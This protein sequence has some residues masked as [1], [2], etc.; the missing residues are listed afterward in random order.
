MANFDQSIVLGLKRRWKRAG[1]T[2]LSVLGSVWLVTEVL[3]R[4][5]YDTNQWLN[6]HGTLYLILAVATA[7]IGFTAAAYEARSVAFT[8]PNTDT[9]LTLRFGSIFDEDADWIIGVNELFDSTLGNIVSANSLH[10]QIIA[11]VY[12]GNE[13][14][15]RRDIDAAL[16]NFQGQAVQRAEGQTVKYHLGTTAVI[17]RGARK[18]F[19]VAISKT[20]LVTHRSSSTVPILWDALTDAIKEVDRR[21]NGDP[22]ALPLIGNGRAS[23]NIPPQ[24]LLRIITLKLTEL[25]KQYD[26]PRRITIN[27]SDDCFEHLDLVEIKRGWSVV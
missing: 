18:I 19:L 15:F 14:N 5:S 23:L 24:H 9:T 2:F 21:G 6:D 3:T 8:I 13:A 16:A 12:H 11:T 10:G 4:V 25:G 26:L 17:Q 20:D 1:A 7:A 22:L 27:L